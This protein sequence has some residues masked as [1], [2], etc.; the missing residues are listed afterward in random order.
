MYNNDTVTEPRDLFS[1]SL[2]GENPWVKRAKSRNQPEIISVGGGKGGVGKSLVL[3]NLAISLA[4]KGF[5]VVALDLDLGGANL[6]TCLNTLIPE[7]TL[8]DLMLKKISRIQDLIIPSPIPNLSLICG[9]QDEIGMANLRN[10]FKSRIFSNLKYIE[11]DYILF[12]LGAGTS[13][14]TL[15]FFNAAQR[16]ILVCLP[17][18]TSI[19]NTYR[20]IKSALY[21]EINQIEDIYQVQ[22]YIER[23]FNGKISAHSQTPREVFEEI[24]KIHPNLGKE[25]E[26]VLRRFSPQ[27]VI[28]QT[29]GQK[30]ID[31]GD[32]MVLVA[33]RY[34]GIKMNYLGHLCY[35]SSV[36]QCVKKRKPLLMEFAHSSVAKDFDVL[37][38]NLLQ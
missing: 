15:D 19:E 8:S 12:D 26:K 28:N 13:H 38:K 5:K 18:P 29:R 30:D 6:H 17:E 11:A 20:F 14:N 33:R 32:S 1:P 9:A 35:D 23:A 22:S 27:I 7:N 31:I 25:I 2:R 34:F 4:L 36:W 16:G 37:V 3:S 21:R 24:G 10:Q